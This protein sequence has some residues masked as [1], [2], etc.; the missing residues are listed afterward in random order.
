MTLEFSG[1]SLTP[2]TFMKIKESHK[3]IVLKAIIECQLNL[4]QT[5]LNESVHPIIYTIK[6]LLI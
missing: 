2:F 6:T 1:C 4:L 3:F 5:I